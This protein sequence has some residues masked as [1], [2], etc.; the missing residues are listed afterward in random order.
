MGVSL[1]LKV[2][3]FQ[4]FKLFSCPRKR[5]KA[6]PLPNSINSFLS[7][8]F[9]TTSVDFLIVYISWLFVGVGEQLQVHLVR[10]AQCRWKLFK[11]RDVFLG[12]G[13]FVVDFRFDGRGGGLDS[14]IGS[15]CGGSLAS[16]VD[17]V[18]DRQGFVFSLEVVDHS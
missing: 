6:K 18:R 16:S 7:V 17:R 5:R 10:H 15:A 2:E 13:A 3:C 14:P 1:S 8:L 4:I 11:K 12:A 9:R